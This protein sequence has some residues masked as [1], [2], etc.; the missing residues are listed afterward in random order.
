MSDK[1]KGVEKE[2]VEYSLRSLSEMDWG[3]DIALLIWFLNLTNAE[4]QD[5]YRN[6]TSF[7]RNTDLETLMKFHSDIAL[8]L[9][10][11]YSFSRDNGRIEEFLTGKLVE[12]SHLRVGITKDSHVRVSIELR[13]PN[14][15]NAVIKDI[16]IDLIC[17]F[18]NRE[19]WIDHLGRCAH[20]KTWFERSRKDQLYCSESCRSKA[21]YTRYRESRKTAERKLYHDDN[22]I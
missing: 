18:L 14:G 13:D 6:S 4:L 8:V 11:F 22:R 17:V 12:A 2:K 5:A 7:K 10:F 20:C 16:W 19:D 1:Q 21:A 9:D 3:T 15:F